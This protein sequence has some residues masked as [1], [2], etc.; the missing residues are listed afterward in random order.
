MRRHTIGEPA[1]AA[2]VRP[3]HEAVL[4]KAVDGIVTSWNEGA[5]L[6]HGHGTDQMVGTSSDLTTPAE[7]L[8]ER[9]LRDADHIESARLIVQGGRHLLELINE[10]L[11]IARIEGAELST[12]SEAASFAN[13]EVLPCPTRIKCRRTINRKRSLPCEQRGSDMSFTVNDLSK[14]YPNKGSSL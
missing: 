6:L 2:I 11:D 5:T 1:L 7:A 14:D 13:S 4:A 3:Y 10:V 9:H 12:S 8:L